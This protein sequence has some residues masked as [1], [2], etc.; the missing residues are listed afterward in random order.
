MS[1]IALKTSRRL[2]D[3]YEL[4]KLRSMLLLNGTASKPFC[5]AFTS[6]KVGEG[7][8][9]VAANFAATLRTER[10]VLL[11]DG[12]LRRPSLHRIFAKNGL[13][14]IAG[15]AE[16]ESESSDVI[17]RGYGGGDLPAAR[18]DSKVGAEPAWRIVPAGKNLD[19]L[20]ARRRISDPGQ[21][22][23]TR[24]FGDF[25]ALS[26]QRYDCIILDCPPVFGSSG[27][28]ILS[29][30]ADGVVMV[31]EAGKVRRE[32]VQRAV[33]LLEETGAHVL[34]AVLNRRRYPIPK[35]FYKML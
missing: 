19:V 3:Q 34:G 24:E 6:C 30:M 7:V 5:L 16:S 33:E 11:M 14:A 13:K 35:I 22:F 23:E 4:L 1:K 15:K 27:S 26:K 2:T 32:V 25:L 29:S 12:D 20:L 8:S 10:R 18:E 21:L 31:I 17:G 28:T 9:S